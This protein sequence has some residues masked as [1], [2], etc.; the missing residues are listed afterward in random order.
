[1]ASNSRI[2]WT[3]VTWNPV[4]GCDRASPGCDNCYA[5][6]FALRLKAMGQ[7]R[8]QTDGDSRTSGPGFGVRCHPD[9]LDLPMKWRQPRLVFVNSMSDLFHPAVP[10]DFIAN[11]F[12]AMRGAQ[13]HTFQILTKRSRRLRDISKVLQWSPNVWM[14][15]SVENSSYKFRVDHLREVPASLRFL[16][17]EPLLAPVGHLNLDGIGWVIVG[18]E[19]G[20]SARPMKRSWVSEIRDQCIQAGVPFFFKQWGGL[21]PKA[22]GRVLDGAV[23]DQYPLKVSAF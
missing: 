8:Y 12:N 7:A 21:N 18:G 17:I 5:K 6:R 4:T 1:M 19:S 13:R 10:N 11:V 14:G 22:G 15:V 3:Q 9:L 23:W 20:P 2:E 16:S